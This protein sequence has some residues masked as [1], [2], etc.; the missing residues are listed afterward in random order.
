MPSFSQLSGGQVRSQDNR[1]HGNADVSRRQSGR[2]VDAVA[3]VHQ[4]S[5]M[6]RPQRANQFQL[7]LG[8][9]FSVNIICRQPH[10]RC[11]RASC[12]SAVTCASTASA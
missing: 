6:L 2:I 5:A 1:T 11:D 10:C 12:A 3:D 4:F 7:L 8:K 9:Q